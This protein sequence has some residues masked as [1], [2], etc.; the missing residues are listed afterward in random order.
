MYLFLNICDELKKNNKYIWNIIIKIIASISISQW[1]RAKFEF[2][3]RQKIIKETNDLIWSDLLKPFDIGTVFCQEWRAKLNTLINYL[4]HFIESP[5][6]FHD[7]ANPKVQHLLLSCSQLSPLSLQSATEWVM[8]YSKFVKLNLFLK[9]PER[10]SNGFIDEKL[11][12]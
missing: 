4:L 7:N 8:L 9:Q 3:F 11:S 10:Y 12:Y 2:L 5:N 6:I 1:E